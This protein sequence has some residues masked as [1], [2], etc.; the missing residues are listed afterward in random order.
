MK[1]EPTNAEI[2]ALIDVLC[3]TVDYNHEETSKCIQIIS[4]AIKALGHRLEMLE[5]AVYNDN[6]EDDNYLN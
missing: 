3:D 4:K 2:G 6:G 5:D 1:R